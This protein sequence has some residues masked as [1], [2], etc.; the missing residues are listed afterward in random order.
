MS[1]KDPGVRCEAMSRDGTRCRCFIGRNHGS[2]YSSIG[3]QVM[4]CCANHQK[5]L[6]RGGK[7]VTN[8][9]FEITYSTEKGFETFQEVK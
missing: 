9:G 7:L 3:F 1:R 4:V 8:H 2:L 6:M 5:V